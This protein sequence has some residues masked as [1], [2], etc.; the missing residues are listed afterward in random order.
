MILVTPETDY[1]IRVMDST[2][3][4]SGDYYVKGWVSANLYTRGTAR[5]P[6]GGNDTYGHDWYFKT[7]FVPEPSSLACLAGG[8]AGFVGLLRR[9]R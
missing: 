2:P 7:Y 5:F 4:F 6:G 9:R 3:N 8:F 1:E